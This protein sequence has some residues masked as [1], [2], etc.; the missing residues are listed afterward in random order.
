MNYNI[1][2]IGTK[3]TTIELAKYLID[4]VCM[5][6]CIITIDEQTVDTSNISG[7]SPIDFSA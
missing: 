5:I 1:C 3:D 2:L 6:D 4:N 7:F